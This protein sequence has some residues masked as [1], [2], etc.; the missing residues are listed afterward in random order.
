MK[1]KLETLIEEIENELTNAG[2]Q[3]KPSALRECGWCGNMVDAA[4]GVQLGTWWCGGCCEDL[5]AECAATCD[6][7]QS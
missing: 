7:D 3:L 6:R 4:D 1:T 5:A 2:M